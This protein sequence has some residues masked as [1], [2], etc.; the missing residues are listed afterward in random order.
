MADFITAIRT[1]EGDKQYDYNALGNKPQLLNQDDVVSIAE[2]IQTAYANIFSGRNLLQN[3]NQGLVGWSFRAGTPKET[4]YTFEEYEDG[5][6]LSLTTPDH[7]YSYLQFTSPDTLLKLQPQTK[8]T[9]SFDLVTNCT[10]N[11]MCAFMKGDATG[12]LTSGRTIKP[13]GTEEIEH[14]QVLW[15]TNDLTEELGSQVIYLTIPKVA[16]KYWSIK[17][18]KLEKGTTA[19][20]WV[21]APE[22]A[23]VGIPGLTEKTAD[24]FDAVEQF[25]IFNL[26]A[27]PKIGTVTLRASDWTGAASPYSQVVTIPEASKN[28]K[29]DLNPTVEQL[30]I[31]H[32]KDIAFVVGNN[33]GVI[34]VYCIG[35]KPTNDYT[36]QTT[37]TEVAINA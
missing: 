21:A 23:V 13:A 31:F 35:Q 15:T 27:M 26:P 4:V 32:N 2:S 34:T 20:P 1:T 19:T 12:A 14:I 36:M 10:E 11:M 37:I 5:V 8:Y 18:L 22:D 16:G 25:V 9:L 24:A 7:Q 17:N 29:I 33:D 30:N 3:T 6:K 28:S